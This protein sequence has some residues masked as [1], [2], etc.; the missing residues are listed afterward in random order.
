MITRMLGNSGLEVFA[1][2][3]SLA[4]FQPGVGAGSRSEA[5]DA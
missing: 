2:S 1:N 3:L 5:G 4:A